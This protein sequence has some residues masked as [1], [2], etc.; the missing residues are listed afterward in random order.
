MRPINV[1]IIGLGTVGASVAKMILKHGEDYKRYYGLDIRL[2]AV[3]ALDDA[4]VKELGLEDIFSFDGNDVIENPDVD[5]VVELIGGTG[6]AKK[7][8]LK[9]LNAGKHV[10]TANKAIMASCGA[11]ILETAK[12]NGVSILYGASVGGGIPIIGPLKRSLD[13]NEISDVMGIV[14]G[15][16]NYMLTRMSDDGMDYDAA[17]KEAQEKGFAEFNPA[18]DVEGLDAANKIAILAS[19]AFHSRVTIDDVYVEG[20]TKIEPVDLDVARDMGYCIKLLAIARRTDKGIDLR[21]HPTML[22]TTH[23]LAGVNGVFNAIYVVGDFVGETMF[24][25]EGAGGG[26][27]GSAVVGDLLEIARMINEGFHETRW[28]E[29]TDEIPFLPIDDLESEYY[30]RIQVED[31]PGV[32]AKIADIFA[33]DD[34][35][36]RSVN[37]RETIGDLANITVLTHITKE[38]AIQ[39][40]LD[41]IVATGMLSADPM[42]IRISR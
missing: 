25:G 19:I 35:S 30:L 11:E 4:P 31:R 21:V 26:A 36:F 23:P 27:A 17:L 6:I 1:G 38:S 14:N 7:F 16:T 41:E 24:F 29:C 20:I 5:V 12:A 18:G 2:A 9:A 34:I 40:A 8:V 33:K 22:P 42:L 3:A 13:G 10:V 32:F 15:T 37:Q 28:C 39:K